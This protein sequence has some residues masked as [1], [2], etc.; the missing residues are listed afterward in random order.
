MERTVQ[1]GGTDNA[2]LVVIDSRSRSSEL[3]IITA[4]RR[5]RV[6]GIADGE[7]P[8]GCSR[9]VGS[10]VANRT[11]DVADARQKTCLNVQ[12]STTSE[13]AVGQLRKAVCLNKSISSGDPGVDSTAGEP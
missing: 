10:I 9:Q 12:E 7:E 13:I 4:L 3:D 6:V 8:E 1:V 5:I 11:G 2:H